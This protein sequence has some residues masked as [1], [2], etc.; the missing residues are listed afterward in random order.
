MPICA[1]AA[2]TCAL[3]RGDVG[4]ALQQRPTARRAAP[5][6][7]VGVHGGSAQR[8]VARR[9]AHQHGDRVLEARPVWRA[10]A[11]RSARVVGELGLGLQHVGLRR[12]AGGVAVL[13]DLQRALVA[14]DRRAEQ[15]DLG[16]GLAQREV[17]DR[18]RR[19]A[20]RA[21]PQP[22]S[23]ALASR[24]GARALDAAARAGPRGRAPSRRRARRRR[25]C[26]RRRWPRPPVRRALASRPSGREQRGALRSRTSACAC[27]YG[28]HRGGDVL[29][30]TSTS[31]R[32]RGSSSGVAEQAPPV[33]ARR[34]RRPAPPAARSRRRRRSLP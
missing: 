4:P 19:P 20:P 16:V 13:R 12:D 6:A 33:A 21:A 10:P 11:A 24:A 2:A 31:R 8:E 34:A 32:E 15:G 26:R 22:R 3:G 28:G 25:R 7:R 17:V 30:A 27:A 9:L 23:A 1:L 14:L 29:V 5:P 18:Q